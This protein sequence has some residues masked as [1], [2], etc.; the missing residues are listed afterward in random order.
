MAFDGPLPNFAN[1]S[2]LNNPSWVDHVN[3]T[4]SKLQDRSKWDALDQQDRHAIIVHKENS[5]RL[6]RRLVAQHAIASGKPPEQFAHLKMDEVDPYHGTHYHIV[7]DRLNRAVDNLSQ[8][9]DEETHTFSG[10]SWRM[11]EAIK[12][13]KKDDTFHSP[14][15]V[16]SSLDP[17]I[18]HDFTKEKTPNEGATQREEHIVHFKLPKGYNRGAYIGHAV[19][20]YAYEK[21]Y[22][23]KAGTKWKRTRTVMH[24]RSPTGL[25]TYVHTLEPID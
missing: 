15:W 3:T 25:K 23:I 6:N 8:P 18:A 24:Q 5:S 19:G 22:L 4:N 12:N 13:T 11:G 7:H 17:R 14:A 21:E 2:A 20:G 9:L 16:S 1:H 10:V